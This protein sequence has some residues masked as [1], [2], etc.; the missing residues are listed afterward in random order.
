MEAGPEY[1]AHW[2][3]DYLAF[4]DFSWFSCTVHAAD[5]D[6]DDIFDPAAT[7]YLCWF[8]SCLFTNGRRYAE[9]TAQKLELV[10]GYAGGGGDPSGRG[11]G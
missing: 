11:A 7:P 3:L 1:L 8:F 6:L 9:V 2:A 5:T 4:G 10:I